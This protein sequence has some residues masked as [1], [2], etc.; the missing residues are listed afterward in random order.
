MLIWLWFQKRYSTR[1]LL[2][3]IHMNYICWRKK[4]FYHWH[5]LVWVNYVFI[6]EKKSYFFKNPKCVEQQTLAFDQTCTCTWIIG[7]SID[8]WLWNMCS[9]LN[10]L[11]GFS[12]DNWIIIGTLLIK[13]KKPCTQLCVFI[14]VIS[15][16]CENCEKTLVFRLF[17]IE[18][19]L[20]E[21]L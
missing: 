20:K 6:L 17:I 16:I 15:V 21:I 18:T 3:L 10:L 5:R 4:N 13:T 2:N 14:V 11:P 1:L 9:G 8:I 19:I 12:F 7:N